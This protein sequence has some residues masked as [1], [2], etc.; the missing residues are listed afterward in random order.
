FGKDAF[1][2]TKIEGNSVG[3]KTYVRSPDQLGQW[4]D[5]YWTIGWEATTGFREYRASHGVSMM[6]GETDVF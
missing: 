2:R 6:T 3:L 1:M 5:F 4:G